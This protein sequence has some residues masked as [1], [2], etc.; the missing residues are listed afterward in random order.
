MP[1]LEELIGEEYVLN[2]GITGHGDEKLAFLEQNMGL[3]QQFLEMGFNGSH[4]YSIV[5]GPEWREKLGNIIQNYKPVWKPLG[6]TGSNLAQIVAYADWKDKL[7]RISR[8]YERVWKPLGLQPTHIAQITRGK[9]WSNKLDWLQTKYAA[10]T[11][12]PVKIAQIL[13]KAD[14]KEILGSS[15]AAVA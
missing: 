14:W 10:S 15:A 2:I 11:Y 6:F 9:G 7:D 12:T 13:Q 1:A 8:D 4:I 5:C 3:V